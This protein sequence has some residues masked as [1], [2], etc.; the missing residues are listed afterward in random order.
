MNH[1]K[2]HKPIV[3]LA[4]ILAWSLF[5]ADASASITANQ[6]EAGGKNQIRPKLQGD[7]MAIIFVGGKTKTPV[8]SSVQQKSQPPQKPQPPKAPQPKPK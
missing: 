5:V 4:S 1:A 2:L 3:F 8:Q 7:V 6:I